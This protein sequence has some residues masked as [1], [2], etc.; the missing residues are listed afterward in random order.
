MAPTISQVRC[1]LSSVKFFNVSRGGNL[2]NVTWNKLQLKSGEAFDEIIS[3]YGRGLVNKS[4]VYANRIISTAPNGYITTYTR[5]HL[6]Q[7]VVSEANGCTTIAQG[8]LFDNIR[9]TVYR[10]LS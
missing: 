1:L 7:T 4:E 5:N 10:G 3:D 2:A 8:S 9:D 6:G